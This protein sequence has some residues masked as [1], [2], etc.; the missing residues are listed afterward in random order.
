[1]TLLIAILLAS[2]A[3]YPADADCSISGDGSTYSINQ[4]LRDQS[5]EWDR[6][7]NAEY[8]SALKRTDVDAQKLQAS[9]RAWLRYRDANCEV[10]AMMKGSIATVLVNTCW[11]DM[12]SARALELNDMD[13][14]G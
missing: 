5:E 9:Q 6:R 3:P 8:Q 12:T 14:S 7:L 2:A 4:C 11:R 13:W 10:Y 1:M